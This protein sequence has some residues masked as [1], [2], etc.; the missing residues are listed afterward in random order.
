LKVIAEGA[1]GGGS[2]PGSVSMALATHAHC[3]ASSSGIREIRNAI[4]SPSNALHSSN[5]KTRR[6]VNQS[7]RIMDNAKQKDKP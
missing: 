7:T 2:Q 3:C 6:D 4:T 1:K 5:K